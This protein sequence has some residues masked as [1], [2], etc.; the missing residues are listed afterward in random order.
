MKKS[1]QRF[2]MV[3]AMCGGTALLFLLLT[4]TRYHLDSLLKLESYTEDMRMLFGR[5]APLD[6]NLVLIGIDRSEYSDF[7]SDEELKE[8]PKL[9]LL[10]KTY[11]WSRAIWADLIT[12]LG[13]AGAKVIAVDLHFAGQGDG[14]DEL[15]AALDKYRDRVVIGC[16]FHDLK[17]N[18]G[19]TF[20]LDLPNP[21]VINAP[22]TNLAGFD[23]RIGFVNIWADE[24]DNV[25]RFAQYRI[26]GSEAM[27]L[28]PP[29][30]MIESLDARAL[31]KFGHPE[32]IPPGSEPVRFRYTSRP[33]L[34]YKIHSLGDVLA[35]KLWKRN[36]QNGEFFRGKII[37][38]GPTSDIFQ[39]VHKTPFPPRT[40]QG[41]LY[42]S[43]MLG[44]EIHMN[45]M[46]AALHHQF[47]RE[48]P[49]GTNAL[50]IAFMGV[51]ATGLSFRVHQPLKRL[52]VA[53][54][55]CIAYWYAA[56][57][58]FDRANLVISVASPLLVLV[59][60]G[61]F[62]LTYDYFVQQFERARVRRTLERYVS[63]NIVKEV[64]DNP[65]T[66]LRNLVGVRLPVTIL[67]SDL[68]GFTSL[69]E[70]SD[71]TQLVKQLNEYLTAM[72]GQIF[73]FDGTLDKFIGDAIMAVWGNIDTKGPEK[74]AQLA[75]SSALAMI[76]N[77]TKLN[78]E[79]KSRGMPELHLGIGINHGVVVSG[80]LGSEEKQEVTVIGDAVN[81]AS[82]LEGLTKYFH[83]ELLIGQTVA[84]LVRERF[85]LRTVGLI[86]PKGKTTPIE[87]FT[88]I[89]ERESAEAVKNAA[90]LAEY[91]SAL[92]LYRAREFSEAQ[93]HFIHL[94]NAHPDDYLSARYAAECE[95][96]L[97]EPPGENWNGVFVMSEK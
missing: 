53:V 12:K 9:R 65:D 36:Y 83:V 93:K 95:T 40:I 4:L 55:L 68:R 77:L 34:G 82:R 25:F 51:L 91:E 27:D 94:H 13:D 58:A 52:L 17:S 37:L 18:R 63:K 44:P 61:V 62:V 84:P 11:P 14:D 28:L 43:E 19:N 54:V 72:T 10:Q 78:A 87:V 69:T 33:G 24:R 2:W 45:L 29:G 49:L 3:T 80:N 70:K 15:K 86:Q 66:Y 22:E 48:A 38:I 16:N 57:W 56:Q 96:L 7:F 23:T 20:T 1:A 75:V 76:R 97:K 67:F 85:L 47:L 90:W 31:R 8:D 39:D 89:G 71:E 46:G 21:S 6:T 35:P 32:L 64:L 81:L 60:S 59:I 73:A 42:P 92:K 88:V 50:L 30:S 79:W 5:R 26:E 41:Q 74:D